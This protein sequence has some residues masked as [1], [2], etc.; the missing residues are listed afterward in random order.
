VSFGYPAVFFAALPELLAVL[1]MDVAGSAGLDA[2]DRSLEVALADNA[3]VGSK[4][5][6]IKG[7]LELAFDSTDS[8][9]DSTA[10]A[11]ASSN[12]NRTCDM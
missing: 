7:R 1:L 10:A 4:V 11:I 3:A 5:C 6:T 12:M 9:A 8:M 2:A